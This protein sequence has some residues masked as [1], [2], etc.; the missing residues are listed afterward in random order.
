MPDPLALATRELVRIA[1]S[2]AGAGA[3]PAPAA[4]APGPPAPPRRSDDAVDVERLL[5]DLPDGH[6]R[7]QR[8]VRILEDHLHPAP[9]RAAARPRQPRQLLVPR[10]RWSRSWG[11]RAGGCSGPWWSC[12]IP[13]RRPGP[14]LAAVRCRSSRRRQRAPFPARPNSPPPTSKC[15]TRSRTC[16]RTSLAHRPASALAG[17]TGGERGPAT[18]RQAFGLPARAHADPSSPTRRRGGTSS[19]SAPRGRRSAARRRSPGQP[20][21][22][23]RLTLDG[24]EAGAPRLIEAGHGAQQTEGVGM[25]GIRVQ[26]ARAV[27]C[28]MIR[29]AYITLTRSA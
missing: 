20:R 13:I 24:I 17:A 28:S 22:I 4:G 15:L 7:V 8:A 26:I 27:P 3:R 1:P 25:A 12:R 18:L 29:P 6:P 9:H 11:A 14:G 23:R 10:T 2:R 19:G 16:R 5:D 21:E